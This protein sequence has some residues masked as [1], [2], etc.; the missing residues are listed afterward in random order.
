MP[1]SVWPEGSHTGRQ[2][3]RELHPKYGKRNSRMFK[4]TLHFGVVKN[5]QNRSETH[6]TAEEA[7]FGLLHK[8]EYFKYTSNI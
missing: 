5:V 8:V 6:A 4:I 2:L 3:G 1:N 7:V